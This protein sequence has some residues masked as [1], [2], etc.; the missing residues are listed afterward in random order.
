[1]KRKIEKYLSNNDKDRIR[2]KEGGRYDFRG[3]LEGVLTAVRE[4]PAE[5][6]TTA[7]KKS[8]SD[9]NS[10]RKAAKRSHQ[11]HDGRGDA[12][13]P[14]INTRSSYRKGTKFSESMF[15]CLSSALL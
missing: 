9:D 10:C 1:M 15:S 4:A 11:E 8:Y 5:G 7:S 3:D 13:T 14:R 12:H 6:G 2:Y